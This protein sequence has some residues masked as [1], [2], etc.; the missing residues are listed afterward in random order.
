MQA[1]VP[2]AGK[3]TRMGHL[4]AD[5]PKALVEV[6]GKPLL[7]HCFETLATLDV[8]ELVVVVGHRGDDVRG[9]YGSSFAGIPIS[10]VA[11][12][13]PRGLGDALA[14][15]GTVLEGDFLHLNGDNVCDANVDELA[16]AHRDADADVTMLVEEVSTDRAREGGVLAFDEEGSV[17][18]IV[19]KPDDPPSTTIPR[20]CYA[21]SE[22]ILDACE[23]IEPAHTG[24]YELSAAIDRVLDRGGTVE[25][26]PLDGWFVNVNTPADVAVAERLLAGRTPPD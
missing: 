1:V 24:E 5:Q 4:T 22:R 2:A 20:G 23:A 17:S 16:A 14:R 26:V 3:G 8:T 11:Q 18:G 21:F 25:T 7:T 15:A 10:Y 9:Q 13:A 6:A 12:P 19:E